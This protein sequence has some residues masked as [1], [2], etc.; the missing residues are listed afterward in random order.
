MPGPRDCITRKKAVVGASPLP[1]ALVSS[2]MLPSGKLSCLPD[3]SGEMNLRMGMGT[4]DHG[5][6]RVKT[7]A[8]CGHSRGQGADWEVCEGRNGVSFI[9]EH[10]MPSVVPCTQ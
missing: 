2:L 1:L 8:P 6:D 4:P 7:E 9:L 10:S 5:L 3:D